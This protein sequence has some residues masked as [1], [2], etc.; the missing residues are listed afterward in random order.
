[1]TCPEVLFVNTHLQ[2]QALELQ[3]LDHPELLDFDGVFPSYRV[4]TI[5][6]P[7]YDAGVT[8]ADGKTT[9]LCGS[10]KVP[11]HEEKDLLVACVEQRNRNLW[12]ARI[13]RASEQLAYT[14]ANI[15]DS[16]TLSSERHKL[17]SRVGNFVLVWP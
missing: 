14:Y 10:G 3:L 2:R 15:D 1:M 16:F 5:G 9:R 6:G 8:D 17:R 12:P 13:I 11:S 4:A 7:T